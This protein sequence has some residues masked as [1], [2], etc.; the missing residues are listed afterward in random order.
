MEKILV[1]GAS[2]NLGKD[3]VNLL[4]DNTD[5]KNLSVLVRDVSKVEHIKTKGVTIHKGDYTDYNSLVNAFKEIDRLYFISTN[6]YDMANRET[7]H[8]NV[9]NAAKAAKVNHIV[10]TSFQRKNEINSPIQYITDVHNFTEELIK[11]SGLTYTILRNGLYADFIPVLTGDKVMETGKIYLP[12]GNGKATFTMRSDLAAGAVA[13]LMEKGHENKT[14]EF[15][16]DKTYT[17]SDIAAML[18]DTTGKTISYVSPSKEE[19]KDTLTKAGVPGD[20]VNFIADCAEAISQGEF[21][22]NDRTLTNLLGGKCA[23]T[24]KFLN[25]VYSK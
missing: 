24:N 22:F 18:T 8:K 25:S 16:A 6:D 12:A 13:V 9:V 10:Y 15:C 23:D 3:V 14:Y 1:T 21:D 4:L 5:S 7:Q 19:Y 17:F 11:Y 2:G 20:F